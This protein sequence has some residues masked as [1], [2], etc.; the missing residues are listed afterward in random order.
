MADAFERLAARDE[1]VLIWGDAFLAREAGELNLDERWLTAIDDEDR[2]EAAAIVQAAGY[3]EFAYVETVPDAP[4][5]AGWIPGGAERLELLPGVPLT[6][7]T[8]HRGA[9]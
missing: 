5:F 9:G 6:V 7:T 8:Y 3:D 1:P 4:D 2:A